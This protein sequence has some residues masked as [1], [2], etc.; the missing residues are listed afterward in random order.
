MLRQRRLDSRPAR[1][2]WGRA[3]TWLITSPAA[4]AASRPHTASGPAVGEAVQEAGGVEVAGAGRVDHPPQHLGRDLDPLAV[5]GGDDRAV[6]AAGEAGDLEVARRPARPPRPR[7]RSGTASRSRPRWRRGC[8]SCS[9]PARGT[10]RGGARRR[11]SR[12]ARTPPCRRC[13]AA[14]SMPLTS[15]ALAAG[16]IP[17]VALAEDDLGPGHQIVVDVVGTDQ[18]RGAEV[19]AHRAL[20]VAGDQ[21]EASGRRRS[22]GGGRHVVA[23]RRSSGC[24]GRTPGR[25]GRRAPCRRTPPGCGTTP[26]RPR[27]WRPIHPRSRCRAPCRRRWPRRRPASTSCIDPL[28]MSWASRNASSA[29]DSTS[30]MA[31]PIATTSRVFSAIDPPSSD[32]SCRSPVGSTWCGPPGGQT[33]ASRSVPT[34]RPARASVRSVRPDRPSPEPTV[35]EAAA[36]PTPSADPYRLPRTAVPSRYELVLEPDL[37]SLHL[38]GHAAP[39]PSTC[40]HET[41]VLV[42]NAIELD[43]HRRLGRRRPTAPGRGRPRSSYDETTERLTLPLATALRRGSLRCCTPSS[44]GCSTTSCTASTAAP[45]PTP[46]ASRRSSPPRSSRPPTPAAPS[47]AGTSPSTRRSSPITLVVDA[48]LA[49]ISNAAETSRDPPRPTARTS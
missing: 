48:D 34:G 42:L 23:R 15:A 19:G 1:V 6:L 40:R 30:T 13:R 21:H 36:A 7:C 3:P 20:G 44:P 46:T 32:R 28:T 49:A 9:P 27:C 22:V 47:R 4:R 26:A 35:P 8:R 18:A 2:T 45:S 33:P 16:Q 38:H 25:A 39:P 29:R 24:R 17:Q 31:L 37:S 11:T 41:D 5:A 14:T 12:T 10:R 43:A